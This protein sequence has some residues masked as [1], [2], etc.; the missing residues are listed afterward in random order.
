MKVQPTSADEATR[1]LIDKRY[2]PVTDQTVTK[3]VTLSLA[4]IAG[5]IRILEHHGSHHF[6][7]NVRNFGGQIIKKMRRAQQ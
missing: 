3:T 6:D 5:L 2:Q 1:N 7:L 4:E